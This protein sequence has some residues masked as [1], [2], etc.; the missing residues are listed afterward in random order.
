MPETTER[1]LSR[2]CALLELIES[3]TPGRYAATETPIMLPAD[4]E[5]PPSLTCT[6]PL[7]ESLWTR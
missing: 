6:C 5:H 3:G 1:P 4:R 2:L 7:C